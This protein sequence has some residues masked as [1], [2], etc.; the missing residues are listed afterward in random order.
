MIALKAMISRIKWL[1]ERIEPPS[2]IEFMVVSDSATV[3]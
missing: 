1:I 3:V 2:S